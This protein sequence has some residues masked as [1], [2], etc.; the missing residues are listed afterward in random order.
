M[1]EGEGERVREGRCERG[2]REFLFSIVPQFYFP[3]VTKCGVLVM[4][5]KLSE[6][7]FLNCNF[8]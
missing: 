2:K 8:L 6:L 7:Q 5:F 3:P 4:P 1:C